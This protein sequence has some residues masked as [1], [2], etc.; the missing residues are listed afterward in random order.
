[1]EDE[2]QLPPKSTSRS[3]GCSLWCAAWFVIFGLLW[4]CLQ[5]IGRTYEGG[6][7]VLVPLVIGVPA[8]LIAH[9][10][11]LAAVF[12]PHEKN[13]SN[14]IRALLIIWGSISVCIIIVLLLDLASQNQ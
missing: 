6:E 1:M 13:Q 7:M 8:F 9:I 14:G 3:G 5:L 10:F 12:S 4:P 11:A 2:K